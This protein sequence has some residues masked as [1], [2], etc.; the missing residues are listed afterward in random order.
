MP[1]GGLVCATKVPR[2][3]EI[4]LN[5]ASNDV[6]DMLMKVPGGGAL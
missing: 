6:A 4:V 3:C 1:L 2:Y 5:A